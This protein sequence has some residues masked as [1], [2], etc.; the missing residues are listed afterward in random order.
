MS[1]QLHTPATLPPEKQPPAPIGQ[2]SGGPRNGLDA[3]PLLETETRS[4]IP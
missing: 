2:E 3:L 1:G 4:S